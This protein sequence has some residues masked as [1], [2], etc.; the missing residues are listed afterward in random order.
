MTEL[1]E[2]LISYLSGY[3]GLTSLIS[4]RVYGM[5]IPQSATLPCLS[6]QRVD[7]PRF[8]THD[9]SGASGDL[10]SPRFQFDAW[11]ETEKEAKAIT[12]QV[13]AALNGKRGSIGTAPNTYTIQAALV[14]AETPEYDPSTNLYRSR[15][16]FIIWHVE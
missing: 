4:T 7:T 1:E 12:E 13:R 10:A 11:A 3:A 2:G 6:S 5:R 16:D 9:S 15:S 8:T 14:D